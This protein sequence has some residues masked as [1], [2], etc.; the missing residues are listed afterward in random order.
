MFAS[1]H[2]YKKKAALRE[3]DGTFQD[4]IRAREVYLPRPSMRGP[5][6]T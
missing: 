4:V 3:K 2:H 6:K 1:P 5:I